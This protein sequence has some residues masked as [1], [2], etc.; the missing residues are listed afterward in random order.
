[1]EENVS[2][3]SMTNVVSLGTGIGSIVD[4]MGKYGIYVDDVVYEI[5]L[6]VES[7][8]DVGRCAEVNIDRTEVSVP[9]RVNGL[10]KGGAS[11][12]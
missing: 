1:R 6:E 7:T 11:S 5:Y 9:V 2:V 12:E 3:V 8:V 4:I 10:K